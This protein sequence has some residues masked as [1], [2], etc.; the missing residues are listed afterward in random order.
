MKPRC[1]NRRNRAHTLADAVVVIATLA[2]VATVLL[3]AL[4]AKKGTGNKV[5]CVSN[6][7]QISIT[8]REW[9]DDHN[10][11]YPMEIS[12]ANG[13]TME[14]SATG[15][16][17]ATFQVMSNELS[18]PAALYCWSDTQHVMTRNWD[19]SLTAK[20]IS[21][22]LGL[23][24]STNSPQAVLCGDDNFAISG[25]PVKSGLLEISTNT[26][27]TWTATRHVNQGNI[28]LADGSVQQVTQAGLR[29]AFQQTGLATNRLAIP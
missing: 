19:A 11:K 3:P 15:N 27:V 9:A 21:Y 6:L 8:F 25:V 18:T 4:A 20:N 1:S 23:D 24:A 29:Q 13:G 14:L 5:S 16:V 10:G 17:V 7:K 12:T 28:G 2:L 26:P 22:F